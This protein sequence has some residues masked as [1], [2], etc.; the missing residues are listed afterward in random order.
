MNRLTLALVVLCSAS[1]EAVWGNLVE[2]N[3]EFKCSAA[4]STCGEG[5]ICNAATGRCEAPC[6]ADSV[7]VSCATPEGVQKLTALLMAQSEQTTTVI[8]LAPNSVCTFERPIEYDMGPSALPAIRS[9][10]VIEGNGSTLLRSANA[11]PFRFFYVAPPPSAD[12]K[13]RLTLRNLTLQGGLAQGG[14]GGGGA[15]MVPGPGSG[16]GGAGLGGAILTQG[17]LVLT[18]VKLVGNAARGGS[19]PMAPDGSLLPPDATYA[20]AGGGGG[21][22]SGHGAAGTVSYQGGGG[23]GFGPSNGAEQAGGAGPNQTEG[24]TKEG[25]GGSSRGG[26]AEI[27]GTASGGDATESPSSG[28]HGGG[29]LG[30]DAW[31]GGDGGSCSETGNGGRAA[32]GGG[33]GGARVQ[34]GNAGPM[35]HGGGGGGLY[36]NGGNG[37]G[38]GTGKNG[39]GGGAYGGGGSGGVGAA[40]GGGGGGV[41]GGGGG[42]SLSSVATFGMGAG[43]GGG[44]GFGGG[45]G[46]GSGSF[47]LANSSFIHCPGGMG[48]FGGGGGVGVGPDSGARSRFGGGTGVYLRGQA[49]QAGGGMG[50]GGA[51][52]ALGGWV[53][54][55]HSELSENTATGGVGGTGGL[56]LGAGIFGVAAEITL[57]GSTVTKNMA[58][59]GTTSPTLP[60]ISAVRSRGAGVYVLDPG[61]KAPLTQT[62]A[63]LELVNSTIS[64]NSADKADVTGADVAL[65][66]ESLAGGTRLGV[67]RSQGGAAGQLANGFAATGAGGD[68]AA[69][70]C[71]VAASGQPGS[72]TP[73]SLLGLLGLW[74]VRRGR[75]SVRRQAAR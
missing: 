18:H 45:G 7:C 13:S 27:Q 5:E 69:S 43:A 60:G 42:G 33:G 22:L 1:C 17:S 3:K 50:A 4:G 38:A 36:S 67:L 23:G 73:L 31:L 53:S 8:Q 66:F 32:H 20:K 47:M 56:G 41:G 70:G 26:P 14:N 61:A 9:D 10:V 24:G 46:G 48:G 64:G 11:P 55:S 71:S 75:T 25:R 68:A 12:R 19:V 37:L 57:D 29:A 52:F 39:G 6:G 72:L 63:R 54:V 28:G 65:E 62:A 2:T 58:Q 21:G 15:S 74:R 51:I 34:S 59:P 49:A 44:G 16:G 40:G 35:Y 30:I